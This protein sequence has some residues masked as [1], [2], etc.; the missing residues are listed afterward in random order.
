MKDEFS[1]NEFV[2]GIVGSDSTVVYY[3][4]GIPS[5]ELKLDLEH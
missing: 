2:F 3:R 5:E 1:V 4:V